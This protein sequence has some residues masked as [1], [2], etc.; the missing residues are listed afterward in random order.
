MGFLDPIQGLP[1]PPQHTGERYV[2]L[3]QLYLLIFCLS[4]DI[5]IAGCTI[6]LHGNIAFK[7]CLF[8]KEN[9]SLN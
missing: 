1:K 6:I 2:C 9:P 5:D 4:T 8:L 7:H 3:I